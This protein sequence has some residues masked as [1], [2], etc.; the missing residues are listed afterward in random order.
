MI[1]WWL[2]VTASTFFAS[3][4]SIA[5]ATQMI[6]PLRHKLDTTIKDLKYL[7][8]MGRVE[9]T[10]PVCPAGKHDIQ[11]NGLKNL[12][13]AISSIGKINIT[14]TVGQQTEFARID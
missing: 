3:A 8:V 4:Y 1:R 14:L 12:A 6:S 9:L 2:S 10:G 13:M 11:V 7:S 5:T